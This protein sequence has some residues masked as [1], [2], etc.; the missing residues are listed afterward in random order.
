MATKREDFIIRLNEDT[1]DE[2]EL[3]FGEY[4]RSMQEADEDVIDDILRIGH[5]A[6]NE[7]LQVGA[8]F[9]RR[10]ESFT[11]AGNAGG[12][13]SF[14]TEQIQALLDNN[15]KYD[16]LLFVQIPREYFLPDVLKYM[17][18]NAIFRG[19]KPDYSPEFMYRCSHLEEN[20][21]P[22]FSRWKDKRLVEQCKT[23]AADLKSVQYIH[24]I[25]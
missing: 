13:D 24:V 12:P 20:A 5:L 8:D 10:I 18:V 16:I 19:T 4:V 21:I 9:V 14:D 7:T 3:T 17:E 25:V 6:I 22:Y 2:N 23:L 1:E 15:E 11:K